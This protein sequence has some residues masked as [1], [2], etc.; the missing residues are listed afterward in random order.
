MTS[1]SDWPEFG[2]GMGPLE[3]LVRL[4]RHYGADPHMVVAGGGNTSVKD[5]RRLYVKAS[6]HEL[7]TIESEGF[8]AMDR[9]ALVAILDE[10]L[11]HDPIERERRLNARI[12]EARLKPEGRR[13]PSVECILH[14]LLPATYVVHTHPTLVNMVACCANGQRICRELFGQDVIW[15]EYVN[16]GYGLAVAIRQAVAEYADRCGGKHPSLVVIQ[17]HGLLVCGQ[18]PDQIRQRTDRVMGKI[19]ARLDATPAGEAFGP[20]RRVDAGQVRSQVST[21]GPA[22]RGL[23]ASGTD[24][25]VVCFDDSDT[26]MQ[27]AGGADG[28]S[29]TAAGPLGPDQ[30][31]YAGSFP[32]WFK[33]KPDE[34]ASKLVERLGRAVRDH[35]ARTK[36]PPT[37]VLLEGAGLL[38][39]GRNVTEAQ[40]ARAM[41]LNVIEVLAGATRLGGVKGMNET[42]RRFI[43]GWEAENYRKKVAAKAALRRRATG[44]IAVVTGAAQGFGLE[45]ARD[46]AEQDACVALADV[47]VEGAAAAAADICKR[48]GA[49]K[50]LGVAVDVA[51]KQSVA[52]AVYEVV[53]TYGGLDVLISN[54]GVL[55]A[56][57]LKTQPEEDF[58]LVTRVNYKGYFL[59]VQAA[60][61][62]MAAQRLANGDYT[63]DIIQINSKSGL[64]G[65]N[66]N[67]AYAGSKFGGIGLTQSFALELIADG[68]KVNSICPG[69][70]FD[71]PLWSDP[72]S[73]LFAQYL[74]AGKVP[75]AKTVQDVRRAYEAM[76]PMQR[77]C[78][79]AD[80]M[81]AA[82]Y[83]IAQ[84][85]E[86]GQALAVTGGQV[87]LR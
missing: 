74:R 1:E 39:S 71:G 2:D 8:V 57:S 27:L 81:E 29:A 62:V 46:L 69:N 7:G 33:P 67:A 82:Y 14:A 63:G 17:N 65:S 36:V 45:I 61:P 11:G 23:L 60:A 32:M 19:A 78:T 54:A 58:D 53:R 51:D 49:G 50:A 35:E 34:P 68:I 13:R 87:M 6:G 18:D 64:A 22:L 42:Q 66:R 10:D 84:Q 3:K 56:E 55:R 72:E 38:A 80:V 59:C 28:A 15:T 5:G 16:P 40:T 20:V 47:N 48:H 31:V 52:D 24:L 77:G 76:V 75:G 4:S 83:L 44:K 30:I 43:A 73:G 41:Y 70:Y 85:Y 25:P 26:V 79:T 37:V 12:S 21:I 9:E 86:T